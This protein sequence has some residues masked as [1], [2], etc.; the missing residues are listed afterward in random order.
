MLM[1]M[2]LG[3]LSKDSYLL[4]P[5]MFKLYLD[6][7]GTNVSALLQDVNGDSNEWPLIEAF[8]KSKHFGAAPYLAI[9]NILY[10][11][12]REQA[13]SFPGKAVN[14]DKQKR[15]H[16]GDVSDVAFIS[17]VLPYVSDIVVDARF[18]DLL[19]KPEMKAHVGSRRVW[20]ARQLDRLIAEA[21][22]DLDSRDYRNMDEVFSRLAPLGENEFVPHRA[23][24]RLIY[25]GNIC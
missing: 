13:Q 11:Y 16:R 25:G 20:S 21:Q 3:G 24:E 14:L 9:D 1:L 22:T 23:G 7:V 2:T 10:A 12:L 6:S 5:G 19:A 15:K 4:K 8:L 18:A 17:V